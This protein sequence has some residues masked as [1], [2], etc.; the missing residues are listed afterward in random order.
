MLAA[1]DPVNWSQLGRRLELAARRR[2]I[3]VPICVRRGHDP[4]P[5]IA[6]GSLAGRGSIRVDVRPPRGAP[7]WGSESAGV[8]SD[9]KTV[10]LARPSGHSFWH[11]LWFR[12]STRPAILRTV[13]V[14]GLASFVS[15]IG[16]GP[17]NPIR[18]QEDDEDSGVV[19][20]GWDADAREEQDEWGMPAFRERHI[21]VQRLSPAFGRHAGG[22][23][24]DVTGK[25]LTPALANPSKS[26]LWNLSRT[27]S[28]TQVM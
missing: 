4:E 9:G 11:A 24:V 2:P 27:C 10:M 7:R 13:L 16:P 22:L 8:G 1:I 6:R 15:S 3:S 28:A 14:L 19:L 5:T 12:A 23:L 18:A 25:G 26:S 17:H 20:Y 21:K